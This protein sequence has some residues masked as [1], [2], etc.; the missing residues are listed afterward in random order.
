MDKNALRTSLVEFLGDEQGSVADEILDG[1]DTRQRTVVDQQMIT[2][3]SEDSTTNETDESETV[4]TDGEAVSGTVVE[5]DDNTISIIADAVTARLS[6]ALDARLQP[7]IDEAIGRS[8]VIGKITGQLDQMTAIGDRLSS[9]ERSD[10]SRLIRVMN[11]LPTPQQEILRV[12]YR[13]SEP[14]KPEDSERNQNPHI[15]QPATFSEMLAEQ[16]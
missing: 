2:R 5:I 8:E 15:N 16:S 4:E 9:L 11:D 1:V 10:Q 6:T 13:P 7:L 14:G 12:G 3:E